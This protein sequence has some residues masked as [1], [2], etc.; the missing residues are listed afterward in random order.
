MYLN[1]PTGKDE[2]GLKEDEYLSYDGPMDSPAEGDFPPSIEE[3]ATAVEVQSQ[4]EANASTNSQPLTPEQVQQI[5]DNLYAERQNQMRQVELE[6]QRRLAEI[7][8][9]AQLAQLQAVQAQQAAANPMNEFE[10]AVEAAVNA[11]LAQTV[12][13]EM[14]RIR[15][16]MAEQQARAAV[17]ATLGAGVNNP[18]MPNFE[19]LTSLTI[20]RYGKDVVMSRIMN[21]SPQDAAK[22][23]YQ[24][25]LAEANAM[26]MATNQVQPQT[27]KATAQPVAQKPQLPR[28]MQVQGGSQASSEADWAEIDRKI[29]AMDRFQIQEFRKNPKNNELFE[30]MLTYGTTNPNHPKLDASRFY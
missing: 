19:A 10:K 28:G 16:E 22:W 1:A 14:N 6:H 4:Q 17:Q 18:D 13:P 11:R 25:G 27:P 2:M 29:D 3:E 5:R 23:L 24:L 7:N 8:A 12:T 9:Q 30:R 26:P 21:S 15:Q 20:Q